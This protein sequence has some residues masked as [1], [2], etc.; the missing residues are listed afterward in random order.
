MTVI[1]TIN[2]IKSRLAKIPKGEWKDEITDEGDCF[3]VAPE[4]H[5]YFYGDLEDTDS[6]C[7]YLA[8]FIVHAKD[9]IEFLLEELE[10]RLD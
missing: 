4:D 10:M 8:D 2:E 5:A 6:C 1:S 9:D 7:H 3:I